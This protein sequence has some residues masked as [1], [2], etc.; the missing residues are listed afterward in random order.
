MRN[1]FLLFLFTFS[2]LLSFNFI[3]QETDRDFSFHGIWEMQEWYYN[4]TL[5][6]QSACPL[7]GTLNI[8]ADGSFV[9]HSVNLDC[10]GRTIEGK[11][12]VSENNTFTMSW[13][14]EREIPQEILE[15][16]K[17]REIKMIP[18]QI[19]LTYAYSIIDPNHFKIQLRMSAV[20]DTIDRRLIFETLIETLIWQ[21]VEKK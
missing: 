16:Y 12:L 3:N 8:E 15:K 6:D 7:K 2:L 18:D 10:R 19:D 1:Y 14:K 4:D 11:W 20:T 13:E 5:L 9:Y 17:G 21:R